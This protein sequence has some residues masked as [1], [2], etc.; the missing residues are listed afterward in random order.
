MMKDR[1]ISSISSH[2]PQRMCCQMTLELLIE[3]TA[4]LYST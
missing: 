1:S 2:L 4:R 3:E